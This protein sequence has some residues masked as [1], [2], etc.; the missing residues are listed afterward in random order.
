MI[1]VEQ[2]VRGKKY[3]ATE[4]FTFETAMEEKEEP[5]D[6]LND[7]PVIPKKSLP[8]WTEEFAYKVLEL[9]FALLKGCG[10]V[11]E[12]RTW[13]VRHIDSVGFIESA[14]YKKFV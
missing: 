14:P 1:I 5:V 11:A 7:W 8:V 6:F 2:M 12:D 10:A 3:T 13:E 4:R 9:D